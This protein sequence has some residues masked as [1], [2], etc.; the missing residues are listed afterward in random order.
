MQRR[1]IAHTEHFDAVIKVLTGGGLL[2]AAYDADGRANAMAIGWGALGSIW[3]M[4]MWIVLVRP[5][6]YTY[7]CVEHA[8]AFSVNVPGA[9]LADAVEVCGTQSGRDGDKLAACGLTVTRGDAGAP[10]LDACPIV[11]ECQVVHHNDLDPAALSGQVAT[12]F[13][14]AGDYHRCYYGR[15]VS[16]LAAED[17][18]S[19]LG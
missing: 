8:G 18:A 1:E 12:G 7:S 17:A 15:I 5:S 10:L 16:A 9:D 2:L 13:Y 3:G 19:R 4:P 6:R 11:Y 14:A